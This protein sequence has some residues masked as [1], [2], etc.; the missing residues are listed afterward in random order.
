MGIDYAGGF[1]EYVEKQKTVKYDICDIIAL[2]SNLDSFWK[3]HKSCTEYVK[4]EN[5]NLNIL[6]KILLNKFIL[7]INNNKFTCDFYAKNYNFIKNFNKYS[8]IIVFISKY[9]FNENKLYDLMTM[10]S[11]LER[12]KKNIV[13]IIMLLRQL[14]NL[15]FNSFFLTFELTPVFNILSTKLSLTI[16]HHPQTTI[17]I[18]MTL[19]YLCNI[20]Q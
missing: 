17:L 12:N 10:Y 13:K 6:E 18:I 20:L 3:F 8:D 4:S 11:Y 19:L 9:Y 5:A 14:Q 7:P 2:C 16:H 1:P 15:G